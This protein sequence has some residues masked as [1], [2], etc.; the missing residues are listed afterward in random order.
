MDRLAQLN[1][2]LAASVDGAGQPIKG[3]GLRVA[4]LRVEIAKLETARARTTRGPAESSTPSGHA[5]GCD[6]HC[7]QYTHECTC[8]TIPRSGRD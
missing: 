3:Y 5:P 8:G 4:T 1:A 6:W 7:D 2:R